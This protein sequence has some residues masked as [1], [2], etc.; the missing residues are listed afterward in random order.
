M[1]YLPPMSGLIANELRLDSGAIQV[2]L[3]EGRTAEVL[4]N[5]C[6]ALS[7]RKEDPS[8]WQSLEKRMRDL[9]GITLH[10]PDYVSERGELSMTYTDARSVT[11]DLSAAGR[12]LQ[13]TLLLLAF[14]LDNPG[15]VLLL[16]EPDAHLEIL[17]QR[18]IYNTLTEVASQ[19]DSQIIAASHSEVIL[20]EAADR[21]VV[22]AFV[23]KPHRIDD[24]GSQLLKSRKTI[25]FDQYLLAEETGWVLYME[26]ATDLAILRAFATT[27]GHP[28]AE[29]LERP[30]VHY[31]LNQPKRAY[32][33][34]NGLREA[35]PDLVGLVIV[36]RLNRDFSGSDLLPVLQWQRREIENYLCFPDVLEAFAARLASERAAGP[37]FESVEAERFRDVMRR[38][39]EDRVPPAALRDPADRWWRDVKASD[40]FLDPV[41]ESFFAQLDLPNLMCK[42]DYHRLAELVAVDDI[43]PE[44]ARVLDQMVRVARSAQPLGAGSEP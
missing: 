37:L 12:G 22:V 10:R 13:Q 9:F 25:G 14:L 3:G 16:D 31:I 26:G 28:A 27:L 38:C 20:N 6:Y 4:R 35:K 11:L 43:D 2:R 40:D 34:F 17:R 19:S 21:D 42:N 5:L 8:R 44:I 32:D 29:A 15:C 18:Q 24:R 30:F 39:L 33:H 7:S 23:G 1:A 36:D 41:F